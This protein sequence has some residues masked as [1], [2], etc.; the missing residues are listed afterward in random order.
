M[1][2]SRTRYGPSPPPHPGPL[3][4][5]IQFPQTPGRSLRSAWLP[6]LSARGGGEGRDAGWRR[7]LSR[8]SWE[9]GVRG[10][11]GFVRSAIYPIRPDRASGVGGRER[12]RG[13]AACGHPGGL[14][15]AGRG[16][17][18]RHRAARRRGCARHQGGAAGGRLRPLLRPPR[19]RR[20][21][22]VR[23]AQ[24]GQGIGRPRHQG[25]GRQRAAAPHRR[26]A[27]TSSCRTS[28]RARQHAPA[29]IRTSCGAGIRASSPATSAAMARAAPT[30]R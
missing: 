26:D 28:R 14:G 22:L 27:R 23:L 13:R 7:F 17:A 5:L 15:G 29:S 2:L 18:L 20:M 6:R 16:G 21:R 8:S 1:S 30:P 3:L 12:S 4:P 10:Q 9:E 11:V 19:G 24:P 25:R